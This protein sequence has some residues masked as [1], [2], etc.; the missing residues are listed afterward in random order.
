MWS[1]LGV[2]PDIS[3]SSINNGQFADTLTLLG[4]LTLLVIVAFIIAVIAHDGN[5]IKQANNKLL[6][7]WCAGK[8]ENILRDLL[9][10]NG[11]ILW[12]VL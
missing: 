1:G 10:T 9:F 2:I 12:R 3:I 7:L 6:G 5:K 11:G 8:K 4:L